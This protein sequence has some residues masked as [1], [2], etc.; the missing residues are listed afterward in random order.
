VL[1]QAV[2][3]FDREVGKTANGHHGGIIG[4]TPG[5]FRRLTQAGQG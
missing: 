2:L 1:N 4:L 5:D 3:A